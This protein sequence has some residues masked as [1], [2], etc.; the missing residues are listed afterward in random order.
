MSANH[1]STHQGR[2]AKAGAAVADALRI[3]PV[4]GDPGH[5]PPGEIAEDLAIIFRK[6]LGPCERLTLA[7]AAMLSL[8]PDNRDALVRAAVRAERA[9]RVFRR[10]GPM[11]RPPS[12]TPIEQ[13]RAAAISFDT[14]PRET[15]AAAW[16][17]AS[18]KDRRDLVAL[19]TGRAAA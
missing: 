15:L 2:L 13:R 5:M 7:S 12:P 9:E 8:D 6:R 10:V 14:T 17:G 11:H 4:A 18:D 16:T 19:A 1:V 3:L